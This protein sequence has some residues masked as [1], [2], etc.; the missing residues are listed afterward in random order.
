MIKKLRTNWLTIAL[1]VVVIIS[2]I[3]SG[4]IWTNPFQYD[5]VRRENA[6]G[7]QQYTTQSMGDVY[8]PTT[9][10][11]TDQR[12]SQSIL[13]PGTGYEGQHPVLAIWPGER[14]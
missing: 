13:Y 11:R 7:G 12:G 10:V 5:G 6:R 2:L 3:L 4:L 8:L 1:A 9:V 14:G